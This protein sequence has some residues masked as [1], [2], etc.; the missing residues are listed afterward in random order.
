[1]NAQTDTSPALEALKAKHT[2]EI[3]KFE[4]EQALAVQLP[5]FGKSITWNGEH[6]EHTFEIAPWLFHGAFMG[7]EHVAYKVPDIHAVRPY[8][9]NYGD[10]YKRLQRDYVRALVECYRN[11]LGEWTAVKGTYASMVPQC[12]DWP[13]HRDYENAQPF[14]DGA[15]LI[16]VDI[17]SGYTSA[18]LEFL[19]ME[20]Q[21]VRITIDVPVPYA[22]APH[23]G[24]AVRDRDGEIRRVERWDLPPMP[25]GGVHRFSY[26]GGDYKN[27]SRHVVYLFAD[28]DSALDALGFGLETVTP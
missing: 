1:M 3:A 19:S 17:G 11:S 14:A 4:K 24:A 6:G 13:N 22:I 5:T 20:P 23:I 7:A 15:A 28:I 9:S 26:G 8:E 27:L 16:S 25:D 2:A 21:P 18:K 12:F 10:A